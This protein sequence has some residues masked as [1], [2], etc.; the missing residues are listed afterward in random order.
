MAK[1]QGKDHLLGLPSTVKPLSRM[2]CLGVVLSSPMSARKVDLIK[3]GVCIFLVFHVS[4]RDVLISGRLH[5]LSILRWDMS[6]CSSGS[7]DIYIVQVYYT[8]YLIYYD[9]FIT[10]N[11]LWRWKTETGELANVHLDLSVVYSLLY[12]WRF[13]FTSLCIHSV[14]I[15]IPSVSLWFTVYL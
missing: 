15:V 8:L 1:E 3:L 5:L 13:S 2:N 11:I 10:W 12:A 6:D 14:V 7:I 4:T 9:M